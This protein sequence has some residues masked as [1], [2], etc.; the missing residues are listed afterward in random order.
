MEDAAIVERSDETKEA[1]FRGPA[2]PA[3][4]RFRRLR[5]E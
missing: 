3:D 4:L 5:E 1:M 2:D